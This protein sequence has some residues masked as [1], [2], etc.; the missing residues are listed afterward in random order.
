MLSVA[1]IPIDGKLLFAPNKAEVPVKN[2]LA[3]TTLLFVP[4]D[5]IAVALCSVLLWNVAIYVF[6]SF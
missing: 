5:A 2:G 1:V 3:K 4:P 6:D